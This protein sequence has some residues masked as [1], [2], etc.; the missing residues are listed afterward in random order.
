[1]TCKVRNSRKILIIKFRHFKTWKPS[2]INSPMF[3]VKKAW[4]ENYRRPFWSLEVSNL[5]L[6]SMHFFQKFLQFPFPP[7]AVSHRLSVCE[8]KHDL[9]IHPS[10]SPHCT[11]LRNNT[12]AIY[13]LCLSYDAEC[14]ECTICGDQTHLCVSSIT[15]F[16]IAFLL[17]VIDKGSLLWTRGNYLM[18]I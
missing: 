14:A 9:K 11:L 17:Q 1:M 15:Y 7:H 16:N 5:M 12:T 3:S 8:S 6:L 10:I 2:K 4:I 18:F 13:C